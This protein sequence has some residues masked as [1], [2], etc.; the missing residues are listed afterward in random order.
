MQANV[1]LV[2]S[3]TQDPEQGSPTGVVL[4]AD[5]LTDAQMQNIAT[6]LNFAESAFVQSPTIEGA[7]YRLR[8][9]APKHEVDLCGHATPRNDG[10]LIIY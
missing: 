6:E 5:N 9:F 10:E 2:K 7:D 3:F 8:F 4:E 1:H